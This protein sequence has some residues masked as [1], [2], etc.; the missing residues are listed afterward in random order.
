MVDMSPSLGSI[1]QNLLATS[2]LFM[3]PMHPDYFS[4]MAV[5]SLTSVLPKW[6]A[7]AE[8]AGKIDILREAEYPFRGGS[9]KFLGYV[10]Q[11]Y[12]PRAGVA[13]KAFQK[14][15]DQLESAVRDTLIPALERCG[16]MLGEEIYK[17]GGYDPHEPI[18][19]MPDFNSLI[20]RSQEYQVPI[21]ELTPEQLQQVGRVLD[22]T[23]GSQNDF[24]RLFKQAADRT[25]RIV[26]AVSA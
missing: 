6:K 21:F 4:N 1:N 2:D 14:W 10:V 8:A 26:N 3:V 11:K 22:N 24:R 15:I 20:A 23:Q 16:M 18:L 19:Q 5:K 25:I 7:W 9:S 12:R 17:A 13:S